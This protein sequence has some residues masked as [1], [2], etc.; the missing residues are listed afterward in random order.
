MLWRVQR[1]RKHTLLRCFSSQA[2]IPLTVHG[3]TKGTLKIEYDMVGPCTSRLGPLLM[4]A[5]LGTQLV[6]WRSGLQEALIR[7]G[8]GPIV[9]YDN[10]DSG[11]STHLD[12]LGDCNLLPMYSQA[13]LHK[14]F[15]IGKSAVSPYSLE[16]MAQDAVYLL[17]YLELT[18]THVIGK[19]MGGMLAQL[20]SIRH[21]GRILSLTSLMSETGDGW[22]AL[23]TPQALAS[24][25]LQTGSTRAER[26]E[27]SL[28]H[29]RLVQGPYYFDY[30]RAKEHYIE[31][32]ERARTNSSRQMAAILAGPSRRQ[33]L[34]SLSAPTL[35]WHGEADPLVPCANGK[36]TAAAIP[37]ST[38]R[39]VPKM[40]HEVPPALYT[41]LAQDMACIAEQGVKWK[42]QN[43]L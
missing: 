27:K 17:Q 21:P 19:S 35:V 36:A 9:R 43:D 20:L 29:A 22:D 40:G 37:N 30:G 13:L 25:V 32:T 18:H 33:A 4:I 39:L 26:M 5:G 2:T 12:H 38:L 11:L 34:T 3:T 14:R 24:L 7:L 31:A 10:R 42:D 6:D 8:F 1:L 15:G 16:D 41:E 23:P 28:A